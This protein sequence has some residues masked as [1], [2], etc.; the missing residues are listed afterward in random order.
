MKGQ[1][2]RQQAP[3]LR[4]GTWR[5]D[6]AHAYV[7]PSPFG[8]LPSADVIRRYVDELADRGVTTA[9]TAALTTIEQEPFLD[10]GFVIRERLHLLVHDLTGLPPTT[11]SSLRRERV[12]ARRARKIDR[13]AV[14]A[15]DARAFE[16]FWHLGTDGLRDAL[17]ATPVS[18]FRVAD[19]RR[20]DPIGYAIC[21]RSG[22]RGYVQRLAVD[23]VA[24]G[25]GVG[26]LLLLDGLRWMSRR[27]SRS[28]TVN[29]QEHNERALALYEQVGFRPQP[30]GLAV[31]TWT[32]AGS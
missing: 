12:R 25:E 17:A 20:G 9:I 21:G 22:A 29:T 32:A 4:V 7:T 16:P 2:L 3:G 15:L 5:S 31:L 27:G 19:T 30:D 28:A 8:P 24:Q 11:T 18:R 14:L 23:P 10:A 6:A 13:A 1:R 26:L